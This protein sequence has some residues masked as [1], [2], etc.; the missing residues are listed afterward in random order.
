MKRVPVRS[1]FCGPDTP[2]SVLIE[3]SRCSQKP[4]YVPGFLSEVS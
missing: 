1:I 3:A 2:S 4:L